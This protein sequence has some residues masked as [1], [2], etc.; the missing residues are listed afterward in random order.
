MS[1]V[2]TLMSIGA[3]VLAGEWIGQEL[4]CG[5]LVAAKA[6]MLSALVGFHCWKLPET[7]QADRPSRGAAPPA[8]PSPWVQKRAA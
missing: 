3:A 5:P 6:V 8:P 4:G 1:R 2:V 7:P